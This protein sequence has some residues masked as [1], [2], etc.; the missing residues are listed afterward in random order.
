MAQ[1]GRSL[2]R[3]TSYFDSYDVPMTERVS[4]LVRTASYPKELI[5][6][7]DGYVGK[8]WARFCKEIE[9]SMLNKQLS[10]SELLSELRANR[11]DGI[12]EIRRHSAYLYEWSLRVTAAL[13]A[14]ETKTREEEI[15]GGMI[16]SLPAEIS[17]PLATRLRQLGITDVLESVHGYIVGLEPE[18]RRCRTCQLR[19]SLS[20]PTACPYQQLESREQPGYPGRNV[21][22][23]GS[24]TGYSG[25]V[26][27]RV[28]Q[29]WDSRPDRVRGSQDGKPRIRANEPQRSG[30]TVAYISAADDQ[31][32][33]TIDDTD[34]IVDDNDDINLRPDE[35]HPN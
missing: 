15:V 2:R 27:N 35:P 32:D 24:T 20:F 8:D 5:A 11:C 6:F 22:L 14:E 25:N 26:Q 28:P 7:A 9:D 19:H 29:T 13:G 10:L 18:L 30:R 12:Q 3:V 4:V 31:P 1:L 23:Q 16:R 21:V 34:L 33:G 17:T